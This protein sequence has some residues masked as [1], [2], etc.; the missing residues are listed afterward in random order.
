MLGRRRTDQPLRRRL[1]FT[2]ADIGL[3]PMRIEVEGARSSVAGDAISME[4]TLPPRAHQL[5][6]IRPAG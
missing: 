3:E 2:Y 1:S 4:I 5:V 6:R